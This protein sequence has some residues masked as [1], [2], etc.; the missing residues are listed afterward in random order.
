MK[1]TLSTLWFRYLTSRY[2]I[3]N[4]CWEDPRID[5]FLLNFD[6]SSDIFMITS[7]GDNTFDYLLDCPR[8][9]DCVDIN[10]QQNALLDL[11]CAL[12]EYGNYEHLIDLFLTGKSAN[13]QSIY[14][15]IRINLDQNSRLFWDHHIKWFSHE[16]GFYQNGLTG[17]FVRILTM[18]LRI[19]NLDHPVH[20][21]INESSLK[22]RNEIFTKEIEPKLWQGLSKHFWKSE[23]VLSLGGIPSTQKSSISNLNEYMRSTLRNLFVEQGM[24]DNYFWKIYLNGEYTASCC[25]EYLKEHHFKTI[26]SRIHKLS[27]KTLSVTQLLNTSKKKY[28][29]F[30]LLDHQDWLVGNG[31]K[32][33][34]KEWRAILNS[35]EPNAKILFRSVHRNLDFLPD[36]VLSK[37]KKINIDSEYLLQNDR[38]GTYPSTFLLEL[39]V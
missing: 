30:I 29:H 35:C 28:S 23:L 38:V 37:F 36:F 9:I 19:K 32:E 22:T 33:L 4:T 10:P 8:S 5:R 24:D 1:N 14:H 18:L 20:S 27:H 21:L 34:E 12:F 11:K 13:Y 17:Y 25:P 16:N 26:K 39:D 31:T 2:L 6:Q 15:S 7:A 3:Y